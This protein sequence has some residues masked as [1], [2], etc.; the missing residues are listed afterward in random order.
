MLRRMMDLGTALGGLALIMIA[1]ACGESPTDLTTGETPETAAN[2]AAPARASAV[3]SPVPGSPAAHATPRTQPLG[4]ADATGVV[5]L[6]TGDRVQIVRQGNRLVPQVRPGPGR[7]KVG[8]VVASVHD[9]VIVRPSDMV[10][11]IAAGRLD[12]E[13]FDVS[14]LLGEGFGDDRRSDLPLIVTGQAD[15]PSLHH[16]MATAG[17]VTVDRTMPVLHAMAVRQRKANAS[18]VLASLTG[19]TPAALTADTIAAAARTAG[20]KI[21]LDRRRALTLDHSVPQIG[22]PAAYARGLTGAGVTIAVLDSGIDDTHPDFA[23]KIIAAQDFVGDGNGTKDVF[24]HGTH[25]ASILAGSGAASGG[26]FHGVATDAKLVNGRICGNDGGCSDS[27]ILAGM[28]WAAATVHAPIV[29]MSLGG[30]DTPGI[31]PLEDAVNTLSAQFGTLFVIAAGNAGSFDETVSS[32]GSADAALTVGAVDINNQLAFFSSRGPRIVDHAVKPDITG[33]GVSIT[34]ARAAGTQLGP[35]V[36]N[37]YTILSGT[38]MATPHVAGSAA[39]LLQQH[40]TW[41]GQQLKEELMNTAQPTDGLTVY[42][43]GAGRVDIDRA[44]RHAV[45]ADPGS[46]SYGIIPFPHDQDP[47]LVRTLTYHNDG[48]AAVTL[49]LAG[50]LSSKSG[51]AAAGMIT[52]SPATLTIAAGSTATAQV[53]VNTQLDDAN[54]VYGGAVVATGDDLRIITPVGVEREA[55]K[56]NLTVNS[57]GVDGAVKTVDTSIHGVDKFGTPI[58][59]IQIFFQETTG[60]TTFRLPAGTFWV[61]SSD[62]SSDHPTMMVAPR[63]DLTRSDANIFF[64]GTLARP[65]D[66]TMPQHTLLFQASVAFNDDATGLNFLAGAF[67]PFSTAQ[68]G[69]SAAPGVTRSVLNAIFTSRPN[70]APTDVY[71]VARE[72]QDVLAAGWTKTF[73][74]KDF[75]NVH[76]TVAGTHNRDYF[77]EAG[78]I[79]PEGC[80]TFITGPGYIGPFDHTEHYF[81]KNLTWIDS[82][83]EADP[84]D[85]DN[86]TVEFDTIEDYTGR[87]G[88]TLEATWNNAVFGPAFAGLNSFNPRGK[89]SAPVR[90]AT[91]VFALEP[92]MVTDPSYPAREA[93]TETDQSSRL[94]VFENGV[95]IA[96]AVITETFFP[97]GLRVPTDNAEADFRFE[98]DFSRPDDLFELSTRVTAAWT[99]HSAPGASDQILPL[100]VM[101]FAPSLNKHNRTG[102]AVLPVPIKIERPIGSAMPRIKSATLDVSFDDG[103]T[104][105]PVQIPLIGVDRAQAV[106]VHPPGA[107]FVSFHATV[108]DVNGNAVDQTIIRAYGLKAPSDIDD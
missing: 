100:P 22:A 4:P 93:D 72:D 108:T 28:E 60:P 105:Q 80:T 75:A 96:N 51:P 26:Q 7:N 52:V 27:A 86:T 88:E 92:S 62:V 73:K 58:G 42:Q 16:R 53:T 56:F 91:G 78:V 50:A 49:A 8:F 70:R 98:A 13:L 37:F 94:T 84:D 34:A 104:W 31:D 64:D 107:T 9:Q 46:E 21:W 63:V 1:A 33:P 30:T 102:A 82:L 65:I 103:A 32:P 77:K 20:P 101:R 12:P 36:G 45:S 3:V 43:Q 18:A 67:T 47:P 38:S 66:L 40:P 39:I 19:V 90:S 99:F 79:C 87:T 11:L 24:G 14:R 2:T 106:I 76:T 81:G 54:E 23:N 85:F 57:T 61:A 89:T 44:T 95:Q 69:P 25:V 29:N 59:N 48:A 55:E 74:A 71:N 10:P 6:I 83:Q 41:T 17:G 15:L 5:T 35:L 97:I 68:I